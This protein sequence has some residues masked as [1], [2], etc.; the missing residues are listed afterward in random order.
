MKKCMALYV[1]LKTMNMSK[2]KIL[3]LMMMTSCLV[4]L[5]CGNDVPVDVTGGIVGT[6]YDSNNTPLQGVGMTLTPLGKSTTT[7]QNG[8]YAFNDIDAGSYRVQAN[9]SGY[10]E[11]TKS[12]NVSVGDNAILDFHLISAAASLQLN[13]ETLDFGNDNTTLTLDIKNVGA[14]TLNWQIS[15]DISWLQCIPTSGTTPANSSSSV[16]VN[17]DRTGLS[18]GNYTQ[19]IAVSGN[20]GSAVVKVN[21]GVQGLTVKISPEELDFGS[22]TTSLQ[23]TLTNTGSMPVN[24]TLTPSNDWIKPSKKSG[25][26]TF[27]SDVVTVAVDRTGKGTG[28][29][30]GSL[31]LVIGEENV[32]VPVRMNVPSKEKPT[33]TLTT[34]ENVT[35]NTALF[36]GGIVSIGSQKV[37][38]HGFCWDTNELPT[39]SSKNNCD[40]GDC[41]TAKNFEYSASGLQPGKKYYVRAYAENV[42]G[43]SY[44]N[45]MVFETQD[46]PQIPVV[47]TGTV[48]SVQANQV[49]VSG[50]ILKIGNDGGITQYGHVWHTSVNPTTAHNRT[51]LGTTS[52]TGSFASTL[53]GLSPNVTYHVRAY[54]TNSLGTAYGDDITFTTT[55]GKVD[56]QTNNVTDITHNAATASGTINKLEGNTITER[57][58]CWSTTANP[59]LSSQYATSTETSNKFKVRL[60]GL[61]TQTTYHVRAYVKTQKGE[62]FFGND[63]S[64]QTSHEIVLPTVGSTQV[65]EIGVS[66]ATFSSIVTNDGKGSISDA[67]FCYSLNNN[68]TI[69]DTRVSYGVATGSFGKTVTGLKENTT[70]HVRAYA[71]NEAGTSYGPDVTFTTLEV[72]VPTLANVTVSNISN[73]SVKVDSKV[74]STGSG[75]LTDAGFVYST[76]HYPTTSDSKLSCGKATTLSGNITG[77]LSE[78]TYYVRA[79]ATNEKGTNYSA[80]CEFKTTKYE[81]NPYK[82]LTIETSYGSTTLDMAKVQGGTFKM[83]AQSSSSSQDNYDKNA[84]SDEKPVHQVTLS[85]FYISKTPV[86]QYLWYV[87][88]GS[89]PNISSAY[90]L[91]D[92]YPVYNISFAQC[93]QFI[94]RLKSLTGKDFRMPTEAEWEFAARGGN[95]SENTI[96]SGSNTV[97]SVAWYSQN[98]SGKTHPVAQKQANELNIYDMTGNL[99]EW[100]SDWYGNYSSSS[101]TNPTGPTSGSSRVIRGGGYS[102]NA[103]DCRVSV[104]SSATPGTGYTTIGLR[105]VM[106]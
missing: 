41:A 52:A 87:V 18:R 24:Y 66:K 103:E 32:T 80:E 36:K 33:V 92:D 14:A 26:F 6:V 75:T 55:V 48:S 25:L 22:T 37:T 54:A 8:T 49:T 17:V 7:G 56:L 63:M 29:Y 106:E 62:V 89:Y 82:S 9:K 78:T 38:K 34:I 96:Y 91:G 74:S 20:G 94:L 101:Q 12:V 46:Q 39:V 51:S 85:T 81:V 47:E 70:Y 50:N 1:K 98:A 30:F 57:G 77:L 86:T 93:Q 90:G 100:C 28:D 44:S 59:T 58:V 65:S 21:M 53:T 95:N 40:L 88:M 19:T 61:S 83:G 68:P 105:L 79:Y 2:E 60:T 42:E 104:R 45:Q 4:L 13:Q 72:T 16:I 3:C 10:L 15:E 11:D 76:N 97:G 84:Y 71:V 23:L 27:G 69:A 102:D 67:G 35:Y 64:F 5:S 73:S 43:L 99:W 31:S